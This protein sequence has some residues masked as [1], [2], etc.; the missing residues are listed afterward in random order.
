MIAS[1]I[2]GWARTDGNQGYDIGIAVLAAKGCLAGRMDRI[3]TVPYKE[4]PR[5][6]LVNICMWMRDT[7]RD[8]RP[9]WVAEI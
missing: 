5:Q 7:L 9:L 6:P 8:I 4:R 1:D 2:P 3:A